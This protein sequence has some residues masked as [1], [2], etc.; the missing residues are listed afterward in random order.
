MT[1]P[2]R[3]RLAVGALRRDELQAEWTPYRHRRDGQSPGV[4]VGLSHNATVPGYFT[5]PYDEEV[6]AIASAGMAVVLPG[7]SGSSWG[8]DDAIEAID[9]A[10]SYLREDLG[11]RTRV[12]LLGF[13]MGA[14]AV[15][16]WAR[17]HPEEVSA[18][19]LV[20]PALDLVRLHADGSFAGEIERSHGGPAGYEAAL[21]TRDP[22]TYA[23]ALRRVPTQ[24][25]Y[26]STDP[27]VPWST[28]VA[29]AERHGGDVTLTSLGAV[30]HDPSTASGV[31]IAAFL[32]RHS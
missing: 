28:A 11:C 7:S 26:S 31:E 10:V 13:S 25:W 8:N 17:S 20:T 15:C 4:V 14:L 23:H 19:A 30:G 9:R 12:G 1:A 22:C 5:P 24:I 29:F 2:L 32:G 16:G 3:T 18:I 21:P 6:R 27:I